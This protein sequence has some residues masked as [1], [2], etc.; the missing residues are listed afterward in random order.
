MTS[1]IVGRTRTA[2]V[3][4]FSTLCD[5]IVLCA[6]GSLPS[7]PVVVAAAVPALPLACFALR[8][9]RYC[10][11]FQCAFPR[12]EPRNTCRAHRFER[13]ATR[14]SLFCFIHFTF[15]AQGASDRCAFGCGFR[16][17]SIRP[18]PRAT[19][20]FSFWDARPGPLESPMRESSSGVIACAGYVCSHQKEEEV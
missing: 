10:A 14:P 20:F 15:L 11:V 2:F 8:P 5:W 1:C 12:V 19:C 4:S 3:R 17:A 18:P 13:A 16:R 9:R 6:T 7:A